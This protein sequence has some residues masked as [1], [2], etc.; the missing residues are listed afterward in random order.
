MLENLLPPGV[1]AVEGPILTSDWDA[2]P[3][4]ME[5]AAAQM[6]HRKAEFLTGRT[7]ARRAL[8]ALGIEAGTI[9]SHPDRSPIWPGGPGGLDG[10]VGCISHTRDYCGVVVA[11]SSSSHGVVRSLGLDIETPGRISEA[12]AVKTFT[13]AERAYLA[14][15]P[16]A[17]RKEKMC[18]IF[19]AKEAFYKLQFPITKAWVGFQDVEVRLEGEGRFVVRLEKDIDSEFSKDLEC[20]GR[21]SANTGKVSALISI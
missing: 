8:R 4:E 2:T 20:A 16:E 17:L 1:Y 15:V 10:A 7:Y 11:K 9:G 21:F 19:C 6:P 12:V 14:T 18:A 13:E 3:E 5:R